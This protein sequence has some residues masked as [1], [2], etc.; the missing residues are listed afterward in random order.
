MFLQSRK[1]AFIAFAAVIFTL[2]S[3]SACS[4]PGAAAPLPTATPA[5]L[6]TP[7][8]SPTPLPSPT[9]T[10]L[11]KVLTICVGQEPN[12]LYPY[13]GTSRSMWSVLEAIYDGPVVYASIFPNL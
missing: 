13:G 6:V 12:T 8:A 2:L 11:P 4:F 5:A 7:T 3:L 9:P 10:A 1:I